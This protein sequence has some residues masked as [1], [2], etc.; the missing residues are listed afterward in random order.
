M[1]KIRVNYYSKFFGVFGIS[2]KQT[3]SDLATHSIL[4][5]INLVIQKFRNEYIIYYITP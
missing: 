1:N 2:E 4:L 5:K 3:P